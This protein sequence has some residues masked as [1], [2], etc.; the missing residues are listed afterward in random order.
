MDRVIVHREDA[1]QGPRDI[2]DQPGRRH[3]QPVST[4]HAPRQQDQ[5]EPK[6]ESAG[7]DPDVERDRCLRPGDLAEFGD[8][9]VQ[10]RV[11]LTRPAPIR[12]GRHER[13]AQ[14]RGDR[15]EAQETSGAWTGKRPHRQARM[16]TSCPWVSARPL[17]VSR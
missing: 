11:A 4:G 2:G 15:C 7:D 3:H 16:S 13:A 14:N 5:E 12:N 9:V 10:W 1:D 8:E 17:I 6:S